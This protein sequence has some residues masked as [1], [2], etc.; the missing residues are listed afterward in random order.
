[1]RKVI[2]EEGI[3]GSKV[4]KWGGGECRSEDVTFRKNIQKGVRTQP[5]RGNLRVEETENGGEPGARS[6][7]IE[8]LMAR[9]GLCQ[10]RRGT[11]SSPHPGTG[12]RQR[13]LMQS[14]SLPLFGANTQVGVCI[15]SVTQDTGT[16]LHAHSR[17]GVTSDI[18]AACRGRS[19]AIQQVRGQPG[20]ASNP[21]PSSCRQPQ[22]RR[23]PLPS[24]PSASSFYN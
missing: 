20:Q 1:M 14:R 19:G 5:R 21:R 22:S 15:V 16:A 4:Q 7:P 3:A 2:L 18:D 12:S 11:G 24:R 10:R 17:V 9:I 8:V 6:W 23:H 13:A